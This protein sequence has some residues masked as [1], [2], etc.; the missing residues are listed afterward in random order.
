MPFLC[1]LGFHR[2]YLTRYN[3]WGKTYHCRRCGRQRIEWPQ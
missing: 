3:R 2:D 1:L